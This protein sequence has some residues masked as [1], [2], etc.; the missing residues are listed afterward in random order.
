MADIELDTACS[1]F[2]RAVIQRD[3]E[4]ADR[5]LHPEFALVLVHPTTAVLTRD[6][7][8]ETLDSYVVEGWQVEEDVRDASDDIASVLRRVRTRATVLGE[9]RSGTFIIG[10]T[11]LRAS[12]G[13]QLWRRH[14][15]PLEAGP[16]P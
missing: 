13:W 4:L 14:S 2:D 8:L 15:T 9:D 7:W 1:D 5:I 10:D 11:W 16:M 3:H 6:R 12:L